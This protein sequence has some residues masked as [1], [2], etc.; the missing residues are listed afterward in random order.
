[1]V[2]RDFINAHGLDEEQEEDMFYYIKAMDH[3]YMK[4]KNPKPKTTKT[5][6]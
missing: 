1:M 4:A 3:V 6:K 5:T 2:I